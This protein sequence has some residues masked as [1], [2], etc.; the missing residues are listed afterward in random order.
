MSWQEPKTNWKA[1]D[2]VGPG[3]LNKIEGNT[4]WL[5]LHRFKLFTESGVFVVPEGVDTVW[6]TLCGGGGGG[7]ES[8]SS[9][10]VNKA[11]GGGGGAEVIIKQRVNVTPGENISVQ[12][13]E[14]GGPESAGGVTSF[15]DY[16]SASGGGGANGSFA[17]GAGGPG[18]EAGES[19]E[20]N[21]PG[22]RG[23]H[24]IFGIGGAKYG[25]P[26]TGF[27]SGGGGEGTSGRDVGRGASG[28]CL[29]E[30]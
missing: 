29:V 23:G 28:F 14:G 7:G 5:K 22:G 30:W 1:G 10:A 16:V 27:G 8:T 26:G 25:G 20:Q 17:G 4:A 13:G 3:D 6:V 12:I 15:G 11:G 19:G 24:T 21:G 2:V 9:G 18:G